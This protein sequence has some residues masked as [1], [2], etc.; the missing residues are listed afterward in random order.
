MGVQESKG[1]SEV[2]DDQKPIE[3]KGS[4]GELARKQ[5]AHPGAGL[6]WPPV[7]GSPM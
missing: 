3:C 1:H 2:W 6:S 7:P 5:S 4:L